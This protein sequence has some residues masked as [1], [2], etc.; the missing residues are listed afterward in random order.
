MASRSADG[1]CA[2]EATRFLPLVIIIA[3]DG[4]GEACRGSEAGADDFVTKPFDQAELLAR[5][6]SLL[7]IKR[8]RDTIVAQTAELADWNRQLEQR[9]REQ[10][11]ELDRIGRLRRFLSPQLADLVVSSG[12]QSFLQSRSAGDHRRILRLARLHGL[13]GARQIPKT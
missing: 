3:S 6:C 13:R 8:Y 7:R 5:V 12:D 4:F 1:V 10:V 11:D 2:D 9:V